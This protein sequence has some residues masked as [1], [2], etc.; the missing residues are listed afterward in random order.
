MSQVKVAAILL[1]PLAVLSF[2]ASA[3]EKLPDCSVK[4][5]V[6]AQLRKQTPTPLFAVPSGDVYGAY[7]PYTGPLLNVATPQ[8]DAADVPP[9]ACATPKVETASN[10]SSKQT[11]PPLKTQPQEAVSAPDGEPAHK[12]ATAQSVGSD[13]LPADCATPVYVVPPGD[14][15]GSYVPYIAPPK[16]T[17]CI[18]PNPLTAS[19]TSSH[20]NASAVQKQPDSLLNSTSSP[21]LDL[22]KP[23]NNDLALAPPVAPPTDGS[24]EGGFVRPVTLHRAPTIPQEPRPFHDYAVGFRAST[25][26]AGVELATPVAG[27]INLRSSFNLFAFNDPFNIDGVDYGARFHL[28]SSQTTLDWFATR[29]LHISPGFLYFK[30]SMSAPASVGPGQTFVL[31]GQTFLNSVD[32][33]LAGASSVVYP[34]KFA[35]LL[36]VGLGNLLPRDGGHLSFPI[37]FGA[38]FTGAPVISLALNGTACTTNGCL[39]FPHNAQAQNFLKLEIQKLNNDLKSFP[40]FPIVSVG[41]AYHF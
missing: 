29:T 39:N 11:P 15:Y 35:P 36:L 25:L 30:N 31:G 19:P 20:P 1:M 28:Q 7:V 40:F 27:R 14:V 4:A 21:L 38:A 6:P 37:E 16:P 13:L 41:V 8:D 23:T 9:A 3:Q 10:N 24:A 34:R 32:D 26:G 2:V 18:T 17:G 12:T 5:A 33:P 22:A